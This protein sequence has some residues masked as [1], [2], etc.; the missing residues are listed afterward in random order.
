MHTKHAMAYFPLQLVRQYWKSISFFLVI[1]I[2]LGYITYAFT[3]PRG[4]LGDVHNDLKVIK[5]PEGF[6]YTDL[7]GISVDIKNFKAKPLIIYSWATWSP[8]SLT[9]LIQFKHIQDTYGDKVT[10]LAINRMENAG[11]IKSYLSTNNITDSVKILI[12][13]TDHFYKAIGGYAMPET[14]FYNADGKLVHQARGVLTADALQQI[15]ESI[16]SQ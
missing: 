2:T 6:A 13:P 9:E 7:D 14:V 10:I 4:I 8:F 1:L 3:A 12:D 16:I 15:T 11:V 5:A